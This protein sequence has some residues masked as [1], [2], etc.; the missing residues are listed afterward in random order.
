VEGKFPNKGQRIFAFG[1]TSP[2]KVRPPPPPPPMILVLAM[3]PLTMAPLT[4]RGRVPAAPF[5]RQHDD[6]VVPAMQTWA[7]PT[8]T[9]VSMWYGWRRRSSY[10]PC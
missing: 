10:P 5:R 6:Y 4:H 8:R 2:F 7:Q 3:A 9:N 1:A